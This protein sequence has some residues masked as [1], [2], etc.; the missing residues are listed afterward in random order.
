VIE[1][2]D[3]SGDL[4]DEFGDELDQDTEEFL[5]AWEA[6][7]AN[8]AAILGEA[9]A[10]KRGAPAPPLANAAARLREDIAA[11]HDP[12]A[13][14]HR[15]TGMGGRLP[16]DDG[17][18]LI[19]CLEAVVGG[20]EDRGLEV[21]EETMLDTLEQADWLGAVVSL[22]RTGE[23]APANP[24]AI[25]HGIETCPEVN[26]PAGIDDDERDHLETAFSIVSNAWFAAGCV[27]RD[28][29]LTAVGEWALPRALARAWGAD[30]DAG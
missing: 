18:L 4:D 12:A 21:Q 6:A 7:D 27:D 1:G 23:G 25:V 10:P 14:M 17:E 5:A 9:L 19:R 22:V 30:F 15:G 16:E 28:E 13:W 2:R 24:R 20:P 8:S 11:G 3:F 29:R 26:V